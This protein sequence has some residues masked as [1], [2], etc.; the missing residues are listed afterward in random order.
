MASLIP[1]SDLG[2]RLLNAFKQSWE[3]AGGVLVESV[4]YANS[5]EGYK[6]AIRE[7]FSLAQ[8]EA[9]AAA[10]RRL[11]QRPLVFTA[12]P[13]ADLDGVMLVAGPA[14]GRQIIPEFGQLGVDTLPIYATSAIFSGAVSATADSDLG[15][16]TFGSMPWLLGTEDRELRAALNRRLPRQRTDFQRFYALGA[17]AY[18]IAK[19]LS[20]FA[21]PG[22]NEISGATGRTLALD[23]NGRVKRTLTWARYR[24]GVP[25]LLTN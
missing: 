3:H 14:E 25:Q 23:G 5:E 6:A 9:R 7:V 16:L 12:K 8:S 11:L 15:D 1:D 18:R 20:R 22:G 19:M 13:R 17:D 21:I 2:S 4:R 10:L 24:N